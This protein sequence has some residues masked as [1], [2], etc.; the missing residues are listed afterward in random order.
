[1]CMPGLM[2]G[3]SSAPTATSP[4]APPPDPRTAVG[5]LAIFQDQK[6]RSDYRTEGEAGDARLK[7][8][9]SRLP[10]AKAVKTPLAVPTADYTTSGGGLQIQK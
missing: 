1:M 10:G 8:I 3:G 2:G 7:D 6:A 5:Q 4:L 9:Q